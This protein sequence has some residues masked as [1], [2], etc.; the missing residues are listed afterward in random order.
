MALV[1][2]STTQSGGY[3]LGFKI[4]PEDKL[5]N[6][7]KE[8]TS[9]YTI[10]SNKPIYGV[11]FNWSS[12]KVYK[13][14]T[15]FIDDIEEG[16]DDPRGEMSNILTV[17]LADEGHIKDREPVFNNDIGLAVEHIKEGFTL[18]KLW[19]VIPSDKI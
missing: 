19:E 13:E 15:S 14:E 8:L 10:Y 17:Y 16:L 11:E 3:V 2:T 6:I 18:Q 4:D 1:V 7:H 5:N 12:G 9:L